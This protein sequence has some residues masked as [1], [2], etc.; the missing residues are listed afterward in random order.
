MVR[1]EIIGHLG[2]DA[3]IKDLNNNQLISFN[4]SVSESFTQNGEKQ[5]KTTWFDC[6]KWG[7]NTAV[8]QF[9]KKGD[10][11][12]VSGKTNN[13]AYQKEDGTLKVINGITVFEIELLGSNKTQN[14]Q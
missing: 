7:N 13:R 10:L 9:I 6:A 5:T 12:Y 11:I 2:K 14:Q 3:E 1:I 8:A 4:V